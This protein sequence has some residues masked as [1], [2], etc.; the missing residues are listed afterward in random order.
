MKKL[1]QFSLLTLAFV[2]A[3]T[4]GISQFAQAQETPTT[5]EDI[6]LDETVTATDLNVTLPNSGLAS[7]FKN[8]TNG[9]HYALTFNPVAKA[10]LRLKQANEVLLL[11]QQALQNNPDS[12]KAKAM[13]D[14]YMEKYQKRMEQ[15][16][17]KVEQ[18][19]DKAQNNAK[20]DQFLNK[21]TDNSLKQQ[22]LMD[23]VA[24]L[25]TDDQR[26]KLQEKRETSLKTLSEALKNLDDASKLPERLDNIM[27]RQTGS[28][29]IHLKNLEVL[30]NL[31]E[32]L[33]EEALKGIQNAEE[34]ALKRLNSAIQNIDPELRKEKIQNYLNNSNS[35]PIT[36][37][38]TLQTLSEDPSL[39]QELKA[40][41]PGI[42]N[43]KAEQI[44]AMINS[45]KNDEHK[46][47][48][49]ERIRQIENPET[50]TL[51]RE[52]EQKYVDPNT[53]ANTPLKVDNLKE[54]VR[55]NY[56]E[57]TKPARQQ[58]D[59]T[60]DK[61]IRDRVKDEPVENSQ[62]DSVKQGIRDSV[63]EQEKPARQEGGVD[64][65]KDLRDQYKGSSEKVTEPV[66]E[67]TEA[68]NQ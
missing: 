22:R 29:L 64:K 27:N 17:Q 37:M 32:K 58:G 30:Q 54:G 56:K 12:I 16:Q 38:Q 1:T 49:L 36:E 5:T 55:T 53:P 46:V 33:P 63:K 45:F 18:F 19:K 25:L 14:S 42:Q 59:V 3:F 51:L 2:L 67:P 43:A 6:A 4:L 11:A 60:K 39:P 20:I 9:L 28:Q 24:G 23:H 65:D 41:I 62:R 66:A 7:F 68:T 21:L 26:A 48:N 44:D 40:S 34:N 52:V 35:D 47:R 31:K 8:I 57:G 10:E 61:D 50:K 13:Y 15:L